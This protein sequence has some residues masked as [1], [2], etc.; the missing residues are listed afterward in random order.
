MLHLAWSRLWEDK[1]DRLWSNRRS[2]L[3]IE[4]PPR[5]PW[6]NPEV[7]ATAQGYPRIDEGVPRVADSVRSDRTHSHVRVSVVTTVTESLL[8]NKATMIPLEPSSGTIVR[9]EREELA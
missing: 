7:A 2:I 1:L 3:G 9:I 4:M 5:R 8:H 6:T